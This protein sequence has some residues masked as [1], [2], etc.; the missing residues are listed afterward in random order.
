MTYFHSQLKTF[1][2]FFLLSAVEGMEDWE[3]ALLSIG[4][5][6]LGMPISLIAS[7]CYRRWKKE[8]TSLVNADQL[9]SSSNIDVTK[10]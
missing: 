3:V 10:V 2:L 5:L 4:M 1:L 6:L 9:Q 8:D 7:A